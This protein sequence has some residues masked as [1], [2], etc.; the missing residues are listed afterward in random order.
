MKQWKTLLEDY[1]N[2]IQLPKLE[3]KGKISSI[4]AKNH[5]INEYKEFRV[6][7]DRD[8]QSDFDQMI[9]DVRKIECN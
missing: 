6:V 4:D 2:L 8:Y 7:Q 3:N 5:A 9:I 1:I